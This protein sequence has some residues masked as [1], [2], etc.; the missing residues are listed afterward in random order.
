MQTFLPYPDFAESADV[1]DR[2][3]L[4]K[5][6]IETKQILQCLLGE[7]S[8]RWAHHPAVKMWA[9]YERALAA[10]GIAICQQWRSRGYK[11]A[12][13]EWFKVTRSLLRAQVYPN[14]MPPWLGNDAFHASHRACL[15]AKDG[16]WYSGFGWAEPPA[17]VPSKGEQWPYVWPGRDM[18]ACACNR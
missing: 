9:G 5:Q 14:G 4:G 1:L 15:L 11:D 16:D 12:Q 10:Y 13:L 17:R 8:T 2:Q 18:E 6:R 3:R 7:G